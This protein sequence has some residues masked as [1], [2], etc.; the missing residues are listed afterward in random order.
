MA[1]VIS[2]FDNHLWQRSGHNQYIFLKIWYLALMLVADQDKNFIFPPH[3]TTHSG[4]DIFLLFSPPWPL[5][6]TGTMIDFLSLCSKSWLVPARTSSP[7][8]NL[9]RV[10]WC[11]LLL[12]IWRQA[13]V[14][15]GLL[16]VLIILNN[17]LIIYF[18]FWEV[19]TLAS[20]VSLLVSRRKAVRV[21]W[22]IVLARSG[23]REQ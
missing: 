23:W 7:Q 16:F 17:V 9:E 2:T 11:Y 10:G 20:L 14:V 18:I 6:P 22:I 5:F 4:K 1:I 8:W 19:M 21:E 12:R 3:L 13:S 15:G